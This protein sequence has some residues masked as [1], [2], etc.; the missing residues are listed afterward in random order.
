MGS[1]PTH[2]PTVDSD[3]SGEST[4]AEEHENRGTRSSDNTSTVP[5]RTAAAKGRPEDCLPRHSPVVLVI[6]VVR[7]LRGR[8]L[9][10]AESTAYSGDTLRASADLLRSMGVVPDHFAPRHVEADGPALS[11]AATLMRAAGIEPNGVAVWP[12]ARR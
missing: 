5:A 4:G 12:G 7:L 10:I 1:S 8:G 3:A 2:E 6:D 9:G 11:A